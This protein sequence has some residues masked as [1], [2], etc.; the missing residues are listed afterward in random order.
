MTDGS[1]RARVLVVD[2]EKEH[3][4]AVAL[5][6]RNHYDVETVYSG[7]RGLE[8]A[9]D[10][11]DVVLLDRRMPGLSGDE[12]LRELRDRDLDCRIIMITAIDP[13]FDILDMPFDDYLCKPLGEEMVDAIEH[14]LQVA[15]YEQL[16]E[17]FSLVSKRRLLE[18]QYRTHELDDSEE[19][20]ELE[21]EIDDLRA[22]LARILDDFEAIRDAFEGIERET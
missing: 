3:A 18:A 2:D 21:A 6:L 1:D 5:R 7:E 22:E 17:Y 11:F 13:A 12:V 16:S 8:V 14:Q 15:A 20:A 10:G 19:F 4:D 9:D